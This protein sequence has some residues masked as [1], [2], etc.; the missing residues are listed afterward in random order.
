M[1]L[2]K[3]ITPKKIV[4]EEE[5]DSVTLPSAQG[6]ITI[7]PKHE[8]L[9]ALL[10]EGILHYTVNDKQE[11]LAI[12]GGYVETDGKEVRVLVARAYRQSEIDEKLT[13]EALENARRLVGETKDAKSRA[14]AMAVM[15][16]SL[17]DMKLIKRHKSPTSANT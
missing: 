7:L 1:I 11:F 3:I 12:G 15:R 9:F 6:Q 4:H 8:H 13:Q 14:E 17:I 16:R 5:V 10:T 2:L